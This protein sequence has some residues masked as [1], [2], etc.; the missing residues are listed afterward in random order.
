MRPKIE[1]QPITNKQTG[2]ASRHQAKRLR[3]HL[4]EKITPPTNTG[5]IALTSIGS[6][7]F[8]PPQ[9][10]YVRGIS[11][12]LDYVPCNIITH[13]LTDQFIKNT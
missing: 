2:P 10:V 3:P 6:E 13:L 5:Q 8:Y 7:V 9:R 4:E 1:V 11:S 12:G